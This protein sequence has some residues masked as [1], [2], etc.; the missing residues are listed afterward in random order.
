MKRTALLFIII[1]LTFVSIAQNNVP[2]KYFK[3]CNQGDSL[4]K[5][6]EY[7]SA[8]IVYSKAF[9][10]N[11]RQGRVKDRYSAACCRAMFNNSDSAFFQLYRIAT[12]GMYTD[13]EKVLEEPNFISLHE[14][15][16]WI[17]LIDI[18]K[19]RRDEIEEAIQQLQP[20]L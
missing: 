10:A 13:Y 11:D 14:D 5:K 2:D 16:R 6:N 20:G 1:L 4:F 18:M 7:S 17:A 3:L 12:K 19:K 9:V 15:K 8:A